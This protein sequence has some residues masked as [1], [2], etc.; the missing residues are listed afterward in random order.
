MILLLLSSP[1]SRACAVAP[2]GSCWPRRSSKG[3]SMTSMPSLVQF[4]THMTEDGILHLIFDLPGR[5]TNVFTNAAIHELL[6]FA[7]WLKASRDVRG[8]VVRSGKTTAFCVGADLGELG[9]A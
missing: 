1:A 7:S 5:S 3:H 4:R 9:V 2:L 8:V 6:A